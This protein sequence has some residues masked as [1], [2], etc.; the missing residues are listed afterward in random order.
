MTNQANI[1]ANTTNIGDVNDITNLDVPAAE[2][3]QSVSEP[4]TVVG[5]INRNTE[6]IEASALDIL[7][8]SNAIAQNSLAIQQNLDLIVTNRA[9]ISETREGIAAIAAIPDLYLTRDE[10][11][12]AA[13]GLSLYDD[14]FGGTETGFGGGVQIRSSK[15]DPWSVGIAGA[16]TPNTVS[17]RLQ[18]RIGG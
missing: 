5:G 7:T 15:E 10:T 16:L 18:A 11:W 6:L 8:N 1:E 14:G 2:G 9:A 3:V 17:V 13:G 12:T 4:R